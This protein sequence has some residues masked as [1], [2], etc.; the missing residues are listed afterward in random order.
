MIVRT[1][2]IR[3]R[4]D[5]QAYPPKIKIGFEGDN[6]VERLCFKLPRIA[7][8]QTATMMLDGEYANMVILTEDEDRYYVDLTAELIG[9]DGEHEAYV[10]IDGGDTG[11]A[12]GSGTFVLQVGEIPGFAGD[13]AERFPDA[14]EQT[15]AEIAANRVEMERQAQRAENA[16]QRAETA[17]WLYVGPDE[18]TDPRV[19]MWV[20]TSGGEGVMFALTSDGTVVINGVEFKMLGDG[21]VL[22]SGAT[23]TQTENDVVEIGGD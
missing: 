9:G 15:R 19:V 17:Q 22:W 16:A 3:F 7:E 13:I 6:M 20:K 21:T 8:N 18:P 1:Q 10:V 23:F 11:E 2:E 12:W 14:I 4:S 5:R